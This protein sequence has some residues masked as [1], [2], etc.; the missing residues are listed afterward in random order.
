M[1]YIAQA[2]KILE[3]LV[4]AK[5]NAKAPKTVF[6]TVFLIQILFF[7]WLPIDFMHALYFFLNY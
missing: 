3:N 6:Y 1:E 4:L 7:A 2:I 5:A